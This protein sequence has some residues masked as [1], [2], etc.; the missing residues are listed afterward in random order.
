[1][2]STLHVITYPCYSN[3]FYP[4]TRSRNPNHHGMENP[5]EQQ[6]SPLTS[7]QRNHNTGT[8]HSPR[9]P[10]PSNNPRFLDSSPA[11][12]FTRNKISRIEARKLL[13]VRSNFTKREVVIRYCIIATKYQTDKW[14]SSVLH[15]KESSAENFKM[16]SNAKGALINDTNNDSY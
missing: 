15:S 2:I 8:N 14:I 4:S 11:F 12:Y 10:H 1:M 9:T 3:N 5:F 13:R 6:P 16:I 7:P